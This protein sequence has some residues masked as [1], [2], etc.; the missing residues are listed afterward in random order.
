MESN[1][2]ATPSDVLKIPQKTMRLKMQHINHGECF[3]DFFIH[4]VGF[5]KTDV[6]M[7]L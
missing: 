4:F 3:P 6:F 5:H 7:I 1:S 2:G